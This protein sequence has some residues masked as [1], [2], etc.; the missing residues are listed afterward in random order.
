MTAPLASGT[1]ALLIQQDSTLTPDQVKAR[2][3]LMATKLPQVTTT[4]TDPVTGIVYISEN[5]VFT[6]GA[7]YLNVPAALNNSAKATLQPHRPQD[8][9]FSLLRP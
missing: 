3:M 5:D 8:S 6:L 2:L 1:A 4:A 9:L 7:G